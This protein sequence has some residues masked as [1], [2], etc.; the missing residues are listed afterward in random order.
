MYEIFPLSPMKEKFPPP[1]AKKLGNI[2][3]MVN[4]YPPA[5]SISVDSEE[6]E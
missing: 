4:W 6:R 1:N 2:C 3:D 5:L